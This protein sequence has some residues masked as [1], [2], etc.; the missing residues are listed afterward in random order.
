MS[1]PEL[2][3]R[4][5]RQVSSVLALVVLLVGMIASVGI[6]RT[7]TVEAQSDTPV[8]AALTPANVPIYLSVSIDLEA[9]QSVQGVELLR[10]LGL[11][12]VFNGLLDDA[13]ETVTGDAGFDLS[14]GIPNGE[15]A[16]VVTDPRAFASSTE[17]DDETSS[18][19][20][21]IIS[22]PGQAAEIVSAEE[23]MLTREAS[24]PESEPQRTT[25]NGVRI[26][27]VPDNEAFAQIGDA[28]VFSDTPQDLYG[29]IDV[30][31]GD[32]DSLA[33][34]DEFS[35]LQ[36]DLPT[37][38]IAYGYVDG[39]S[40]RAPLQQ[41]VL[42]NY[43]TS[44]FAAFSAIMPYLNNH[45]G[46]AISASANEFRFDLRMSSGTGGET[47]SNQIAPN[48]TL[49]QQVGA[50]TQ[51]FFNG[52]DLGQTAGMTT[53]SLVLAQGV[54]SLIS[55][56]TGL[57]MVEPT[58]FYEAAQRVLTFNISDVFNEMVGEYALAASAISLDP[59]GIDAVLI[60][61][62]DDV[63]VVKDAAAKTAV[64]LNAATFD[65]GTGTTPAP[66]VRQVDG[67]TIQVL[68]LPVDD[69]GTV[70]HVELG[71]VDQRFLLGYRSGVSD[72]LAGPTETL[73]D[74]PRYQAAMS[75]LPAERDWQLYLDL[76]GLI[77]LAQQADPSIAEQTADFTLDNAE[78]LSAAGFTHDGLTGMTVVISIP[79]GEGHEMATPVASR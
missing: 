34:S 53:L 24:T 65:N 69:V 33:D 60:S 20:V 54:S 59:G 5:R 6:V 31:A 3:V 74:N 30:Y 78:S 26:V 50:D 22:A 41:A 66:E 47:A 17:S 4:R 28:V 71:V 40:L 56:Q 23:A 72:F 29:V 55:D 8:T 58:Q 38:A 57:L 36:T 21:A 43:G 76:A 48:L 51:L 77:P 73:A 9:T 62:V 14:H 12:D 52:V 68:D 70:V 10:R 27:S 7:R 11:G 1:K 13:N 2:P 35:R 67:G 19:L 15:I 44:Q 32:A 16:V 37:E 61:G 79:G 18:G 46:L 49:D 63:E 42:E 39:P 64:L 75:V 25:Y 45:F